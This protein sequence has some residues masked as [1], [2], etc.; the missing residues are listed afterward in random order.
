MWWF[1]QMFASWRFDSRFSEISAVIL[2]ANK[3]C[4]NFAL[5]DVIQV[6]TIKI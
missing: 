4:K 3:K 2:G 6:L 1:L 5:D